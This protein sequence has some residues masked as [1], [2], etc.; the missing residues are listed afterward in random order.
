MDSFHFNQSNIAARH[1]YSY[2][3]MIF[4]CFL[5]QVLNCGTSSLT[6][7]SSAG[8]VCSFV[9]KLSMFKCPLIVFTFPDL[10]L[11]CSFL[12]CRPLKALTNTST[13]VHWWHR[14]P[15]KRYLI[16]SN[17]ALSTRSAT[18]YFYAQPFTHWWKRPPGEWM[19]HSTSCAAATDLVVNLFD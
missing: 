11:Y 13:V 4:G 5:W 3:V 12:G 7:P 1:L 6:W 8:G 17:T 14:L 18:Q 19:T 2:S 10:H 16:R 9:R 15:C